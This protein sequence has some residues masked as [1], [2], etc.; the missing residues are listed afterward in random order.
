MKGQRSKSNV[1]RK[2][3]HENQSGK[4]RTHSD[5]FSNFWKHKIKIYSDNEILLRL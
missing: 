4:Q 2:G 1:K 5:S 3:E